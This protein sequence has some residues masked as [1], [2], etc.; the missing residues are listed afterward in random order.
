MRRGYAFADG[1]AIV[2]P[3]DKDCFLKEYYSDIGMTDGYGR[4]HWAPRTQLTKAR[5]EYKRQFL[6]TKEQEN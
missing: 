1:T 2:F 5:N 3:F 4:T 6:Q